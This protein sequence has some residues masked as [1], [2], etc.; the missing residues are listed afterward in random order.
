M[1]HKLYKRNASGV[2]ILW[3]IEKTPNNVISIRHGVVNGN[4]HQE[5]ITSTQVG[6]LDKEIESRIKSKRKEGYKYLNELFDNAPENLDKIA[7]VSYLNTY[8]PKY[9]SSTGDSILPMLAK[10]LENNR[11]FD[12][13]GVLRGQW[14]INGERCLIGA[15][16]DTT[17][18]FNPIRLTFQSREGVVWKLQYLE[19]KLLD[20]IPEEVIDMMIEEHAYLDG[21]IYYPGLK[22]NDINHLIKNPK[23]PR[24]K[25]LQFWLYDLAIENTIYKER[26]EI[27]IKGF[28]KYLTTFNGDI[29]EHL[30]NKNTLI[31]LPEITVGNYNEAISYRDHFIY[32]GFEGLI[33]RNPNQEY[34]FGKRSVELMYKFKKIE[35]GIFEIINIIPEGKKREDLCKL[36]LR[37]DINDAE[38]ECTI[39]A[40]QSVQRDIL[41]R[42]DKFIGHH[43]TVEY[44]ERSGVS[45]VPFHAKAVKID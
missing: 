12:K 22:I 31:L 32:M 20:I 17:D 39:K 28:D 42:K 2:P 19:K 14:K 24:H 11:P 21:E 41:Q 3:E 44:R 45:Q 7:L 26:R 8:L 10:T 25:D 5:F 35:D 34:G 16:E 18:M 36:V 6:G 40:P 29:N 13:Y 23:D 15:I 1:I 30:N 38:F 9:N 37:N 4:I 43:A 27:L 33:L